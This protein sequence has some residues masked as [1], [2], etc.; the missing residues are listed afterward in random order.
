MVADYQGREPS[1]PVRSDIEIDAAI[2]AL[3]REPGGADE[4]IQ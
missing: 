1:A 3:G 2:M 4:V